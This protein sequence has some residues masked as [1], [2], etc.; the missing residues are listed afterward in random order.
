[1][2]LSSSSPHTFSFPHP[3]SS[4]LSPV[5]ILKYSSVQV[6]TTVKGYFDLVPENIGLNLASFRITNHPSISLTLVKN[7]EAL[8]I[9]CNC[10]ERTKGLCTHQAR[11][12]MNVSRREELR[13]F[14]D[15]KLRH[16]RI[17]AFAKDYGLEHTSGPDTHFVVIFKNRAFEIRPANEG[18]LPVSAQKNH[19]L[20]AVLV[21]E[22]PHH[23]QELEVVSPAK[24]ILILKQHRYYKQFQTELGEAGFAKNGKLKNP[25]KLID[26]YT[27]AWGAADPAELKFYAAIARFQKNYEG[28]TS[29]TDLEALRMLVKNP[30][31][32]PV[33]YHDPAKG[34]SLTS[35]SLV[36]VALKELSIDVQ[37][38]VDHKSEFFEI[39]SRLFIGNKSFD[40]AVLPLRFGYFILLQ[41]TLH[42]IGNPD[43]L[44]VVNWFKSRRNKIA[45]HESKFEA[46]RNDVLSELEEQIRISYTYLKPATKAQLKE[47]AF[48]GPPERILYLSDT[49][50]VIWITPVMRYGPVEVSVRSPKQVYGTDHEGNA[51]LV[52]RNEEAE[53][54][55]LGMIWRQHPFFE[56]QVTGD[57]FYLHKKRFADEN[58]FPNAFAE[59]TRQGI[60]VLGF[61]SLTKNKLNPNK[62]KINI[63]VMSGV[64]WF[65]THVEV[66]YG[67]EKVP[68]SKLQKSVR[69]K[70]R[71]VKLDDGSEGILPEEWLEK[72][73][74][75]F[76]SGEV[77]G[78][79][80]RTPK[81]SF[82]A[83]AELYEAG[84]LSKEVK[85]ELAEIRSKI[86]SFESV[87]SVPVPAGLNA[88]LRDYQKEGLKWL[89]FLDD[90]GFGGC[91]A[92]DMGLGKTIQVIAFFLLLREKHGCCTNLV[93]VPTTLIGNWERELAKFA[94][95]LRVLTIYGAGRIKHLS[96]TDGFDVVL[97]SYGTLLHDIGFLKQYRFN[98]IVLDESQAI[99]NPDSMR[100]QAAMLL[101]ARNK[102]TLTG[103]PVE[104]NTYDLYGQ[105]SFACPGLLGTKTYFREMYAVPIDQFSDH[106]RA[107]ELRERVS[108]F[109]LRRTKKQVA[110]EL[111]EKT[112][113]V[114]FCEMEP[115][116]KDVYDSYKREYREYFLTHRED[117]LARHSMHILKGITLLRQICDA[118]A[119]L[120]EGPYY[121]ES[122][123]KIRV[124][125]EE[126]EMRSPDHKIIVFSQFV[127]M[128]D[129]I[130]KEL[131]MRNIGFE[132]LTGK[133]ARRDEKVDVFRND[134]HVR[135]FLISLKAGGTGLNL[136]EADYVY[137]VDPWWNPAVENQA[138]DRAYRIGQEKHVVAVRLIC[139]GTIEEKMMNIQERKKE[140]V[141]N[142]VETGGDTFYTLSKEELEELF[143]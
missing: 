109:I 6:D 11:T 77:A 125:M 16:Q 12:L 79:I 9:S 116:Q 36:P 112:E 107:A 86:A 115:A 132:Y 31:R 100:Y 95:S 10:G 137:L 54:A 104:N 43:F 49:G 118:P 24:N 1:L 111:P 61:N 7:E 142:L 123:A 73:A 38:Q 13:I 48:D 70:N 5:F 101:Q 42:F 39:S 75:Y 127:G 108:P 18:L 47:N 50:N 67:K 141:N 32:L 26:P 138:I 85:F 88:S 19:E 69:N 59:W 96:A 119:L 126:I 25:V 22:K 78:E 63:R 44:R 98:Y 83:I 30:L 66:F 46:F 135:V 71:F 57:S 92:D 102:L 117:E 64:D 87:R 41:N 94:P 124:L 114:L 55:F 34:E 58:W 81:I 27:F 113:M 91:L 74:R 129:L 82:S 143:A 103:T 120:N 139:P 35:T 53:L 89:N 28:D 97:T 2:L 68:L 15:E 20:K 45:I 80:I 106:T 56:E 128:L 40:L 17:R 110:A 62:P 84:L 134:P 122:S 14:F 60:S 105:L 121:G 133:S 72:F 140:L 33:F 65:E 93:V 130:R 52:N 76:R 136:T 51:F 21:A 8:N 99:K 3:D 4:G 23:A 131:L 90:F 29:E 37:L